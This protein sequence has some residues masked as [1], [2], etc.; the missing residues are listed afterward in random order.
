MA[1]NAAIVAQPTSVSRTAMRQGQVY[2]LD[3]PTPATVAA[4]LGRAKNISINFEPVN[5]EADSQGRVSTMGYNVTATFTMMQ[6]TAAD[7]DVAFALAAPA[8]GE[9]GAGGFNLFFSN[10]TMGEA[11]ALAAW[12]SASPSDIDGVGLIGAIVQVGPNLDFSGG[13]S[14]IVCTVTGRIPA[15][16]VRAFSTTRKITLAL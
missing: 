12:N 13:E 11:A 6:T 14:G 2:V 1:L 8:D 7:L 16:R 4:H 9:D 3:A 15:D 10:V 5:S